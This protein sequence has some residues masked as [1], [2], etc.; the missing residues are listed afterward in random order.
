[1]LEGEISA[2]QWELGALSK[3]QFQ[4]D[5]TRAVEGNLGASRGSQKQG[6]SE[7]QNAPDT[8]RNCF[9][10]SV[11]K[12]SAAPWGHP[13]PR[14]RKNRCHRE[15]FIKKFGGTSGAEVRGSPPE[16]NAREQIQQGLFFC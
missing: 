15:W 16:D 6:I 3:T 4:M 2:L 10:A 7:V 11:V 14:R 8:L 13:E 9:E 5:T 1:M 12:Q